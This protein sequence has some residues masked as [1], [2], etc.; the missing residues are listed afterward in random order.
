MLMGD[1]TGPGKNKHFFPIVDL[2][3]MT[4]ELRKECNIKQS[5]DPA[6]YLPILSAKVIGLRNSISFVQQFAGPLAIIFKCFDF[7]PASFE[8]TSEPFGILREQMFHMHALIGQLSEATVNRKILTVF[9]RLVSLASALLS[10]TASDSFRKM[11]P[12]EP[13]REP[14]PAKTSRR[15]K[16]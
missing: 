1:L 13:Q 3:E 12:P 9:K 4:R 6:V 14:E 5:I 7:K 15:Q 2:N 8:P 10:A 11:A 16:R